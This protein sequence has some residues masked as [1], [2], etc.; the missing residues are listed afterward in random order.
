VNATIAPAKLDG[1]AWDG[2]G[3]I[4]PTLTAGAASAMG[5]GTDTAIVVA[6]VTG[7]A[8]SHFTRPDPYGWAEARGARVDLKRTSDTLMPSWS[9]PPL[10]KITLD[11]SAR[12][13]VHLIDHDLDADDPIGDVELG[14]KELR[15]ALASAKVYQVRVDDQTHGQVLFVGVSV[16]EE[17]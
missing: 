10:R 1:S 14:D 9:A 4:V 2:L 13:R 3:G 11:G 12:V 17:R 6:H 8:L 7:E 5:A 15:E 16:E